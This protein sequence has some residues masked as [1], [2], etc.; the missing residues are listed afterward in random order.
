MLE[1][2]LAHSHAVSKSVNIE[3]GYLKMLGQVQDSKGMIRLVSHIEVAL[4]IQV[5]QEI[6][7]VVGIGFAKLLHGVVKPNERGAQLISNY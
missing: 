2:T 4:L 3:I 1:Q 7:K 5:I 6:H